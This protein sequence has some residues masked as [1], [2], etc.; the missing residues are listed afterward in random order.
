MRYPHDPDKP[1]GPRTQHQYV[2]KAIGIAASALP[3]QYKRYPVPMPH[4]G[5]RYTVACP[6]FQKRVSTLYRYRYAY[7]YAT[8][9]ACRQCCGLVYRSQYEMRR[10]EASK[11]RIDRLSD[12][13]WDMPPSP[14]RDRIWRRLSHASDVWCARMDNYM[15]QREFRLLVALS[16]IAA[17]IER[18]QARS[19][20]RRQYMRLYRRGCNTADQL[21]RLPRVETHILTFDHVLARIDAA[22]AA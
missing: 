19:E 1:Y 5:V 8:Y 6:Q 14:A 7:G 15:L 9:Y 12:Q 10:P 2:D 11:A 4:G 20:R 17:R 13:W 3:V 22:I 21:E 16:T 18:D